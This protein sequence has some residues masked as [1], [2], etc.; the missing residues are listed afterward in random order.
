MIK[1]HSMFFNTALGGIVFGFWQH[2]ILAGFA[3]AALLAAISG[4]IDEESKLKDT[5]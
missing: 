2:S 1:F 3:F 4:T 5:P